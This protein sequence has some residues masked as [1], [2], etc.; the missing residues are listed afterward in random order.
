MAKGTVKIHSENILPIIKKSLYSDVDIFLRELTSNAAD[1]LHKLKILHD[2]GA[3]PELNIDN[4]KIEVT[5]DAKNK[6][7]TIS[8]T[9]IGMT[10]E[11]IEK[12]IAQIAF[13]GAEE[14]VSKYSSNKESDQI[15][16]HF[17]LGFYS[18]FMVSKRV[19]ILSKSYQLDT[20]AAFWSCDGSS[21]YEI[22]EAEKKE[23]GT[24][25]TLYINSDSEEFLEETKVRETLKKYCSF[26][27]YPLFFQGK[28][29]NERE[30]IW[31][32]KPSD[33]SEKD[34]KEFFRYL[35][36]LEPEPIFWIH[37]NVDFPFHL[38]G[39][40]Y[41]PKISKNFDFSKSN[42]QLYYSRVFVSDSCKDLIPDYLIML[43]GTIDSPDIP[44]NVSRS[45][46]QM[47][48]TVRQLSAHISKKVADQLTHLYTTRK[49]FFLESWPNIE[50]ILKLGVL[51]DEKFYER[52][53]SLLIWK[54]L[55]GEWNTVEEYLERNKS[56]H[57][58]KVFYV[59]GDMGEQTQFLNLYKEKGIEVLIATSY[60]DTSI[61]SFLETKLSGVKFQRVDGACEELLLD[62]IKE[63]TIL[64]V[65]GKTLATKISDYFKQA[66]ELNTIEVEAKSIA[67][68]ALPA[69]VVIDEQSRRFRD[70][71][72]FSQKE[73]PN[74]FLDKKTLILNTNNKLIHAIYNMRTKN[75]T[76]AK[77][78]AKQVYE[79]SL[80]S[81]KELD[82]QKLPEFISR[83]NHILEQLVESSSS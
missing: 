40:L 68:E 56:K 52:I 50:M 54:N 57:E 67:S 82:S 14:F 79:L 12:Y 81:Q 44:V 33:L 35:Y 47:D 20:K 80:L 48:R 71:L 8:D 75:A 15:I 77:S 28:R 76:L 10:S 36:P 53:K 3:V 23:H 66:A 45:Y 9:G 83:C 61:I 34:Y 19:D 5:L 55:Q 2:Q 16:G 41:F 30:P 72:A 70:Y 37:L 39:I 62:K 22:T 59:F 65:E 13:S 1:A 18:A 58:N 78:L 17:G 27:P 69:F 31:I 6:T 26:L 24:E 60:L 73:L 49:E 25:I 64:D 7:I 29:I 74:E 51:Q 4:L 38:Q 42:I 32:Q 21:E 11:E 46:L 43:K 63:N